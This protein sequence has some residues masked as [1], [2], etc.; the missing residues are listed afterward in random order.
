MGE[1]AHSINNVIVSND[2]DYLYLYNLS[3]YTECF[4]P[5]AIILDF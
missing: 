3:P 2:I 5:N 4:S 1:Y